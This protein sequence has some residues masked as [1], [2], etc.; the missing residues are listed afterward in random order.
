M[1]R[2]TP[3]QIEKMVHKAL[4]SLPDRRAPASL[5]AR[6]LAAVAAQAAIPWWHK[7]WRHWPR[8]VRVL[9]VL[10]CG[11]VAALMIGGGA[12][13]QLDLEPGRIGAAADIADRL[14]AVGSGVTNLV[15]LVIRNI[16]ATWLY[17]SIAVIGAMYAMLFGLGATA[18]RTLWAN[19]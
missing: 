1:N 6:V 19:R 10:G 17:G 18:Y 5:E 13:V 9:F 15:S 4:R 12:Y 16:P 7:S 11:M 3:E 8:P 14:I 2:M